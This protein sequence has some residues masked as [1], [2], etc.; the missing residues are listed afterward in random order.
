MQQLGMPQ[1]APQQQ[2]QQLQRPQQT[3][4]QASPFVG[5]GGAGGMFNPMMPGLYGCGYGMGMALDP[6]AAWCAVCR[7]CEICWI[8]V[9]EA[10]LLMHWKCY[11][12]AACLSGYVCSEECSCRQPAFNPSTVSHCCA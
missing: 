12:T 2:Q 5:G 9:Y 3:G 7:G 8:C 4:V 1:P 6:F 11:T 10:C